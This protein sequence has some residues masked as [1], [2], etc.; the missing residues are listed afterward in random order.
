MIEQKLRPHILW[1]RE[2]PPRLSVLTSVGVPGIEPEPHVLRTQG[3]PS[4]P[5]VFKGVGVPRIELESH[6]PEACILPLYYTPT[7]FQTPEARILPLYYTPEIILKQPV[8][9]ALVIVEVPRVEP[10]SHPL[11]SFRCPA[12]GSRRCR[13]AENRTRITRTPCVHT[14]T[15]LHPDS[16]FCPHACILP[17]YYTSTEQS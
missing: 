4:E 2:N 9:C 10:G 6:A 13:G 17:L 14:T 1:I 7:P 8:R 11:R 16:T 3:S 12:S 15:V 5:P